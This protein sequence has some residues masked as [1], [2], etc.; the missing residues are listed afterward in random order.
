MKRVL[1]SAL[2]LA[3]FAMSLEL[4]AADEAKG[5]KGKKNAAAAAFNLPKTI[6][7]SAEQQTKFDELKKSLEPLLAEAIKKEE[8][9]L[10]AEQRAARE[11]AAKDAKAA[12]KKGKEIQAAVDEA[13]KLSDEQKSQLAE[14]HKVVAD[15]QKKAREGVMGLLTDEQKESLKKKKE[16]T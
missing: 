8:A 5:E 7:L 13:V 4:R 11:T 14:T 9:V 10:S 1:L 15:L 16:K 3:L 12:G 2:T 6:T